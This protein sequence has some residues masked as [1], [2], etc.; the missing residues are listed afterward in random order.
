MFEVRA[1][2]IQVNLELFSL[3]QNSPEVRLYLFTVEFQ[4]L[5][6]LSRVRDSNKGSRVISMQLHDLFVPVAKTFQAGFV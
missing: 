1:D 6:Q 4:L 3:V 2:I 5:T